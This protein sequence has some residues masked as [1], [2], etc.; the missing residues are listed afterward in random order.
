M[1]TAYVDFF[2]LYRLE[3]DSLAHIHNTESNIMRKN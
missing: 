1:I 3:L 2:Y